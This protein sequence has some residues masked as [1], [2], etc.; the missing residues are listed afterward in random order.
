MSHVGDVVNFSSVHKSGNERKCVSID[1]EFS[2]LLVLT[3]TVVPLCM[4]GMF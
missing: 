3:A 4:L 1:F 2:L